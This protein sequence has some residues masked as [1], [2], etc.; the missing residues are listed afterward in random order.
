MVLYVKM[1]DLALIYNFIP[2]FIF[3]QQVN[4][5]ISSINSGNLPFFVGN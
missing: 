2:V 1:L 3:L 4:F 5:N